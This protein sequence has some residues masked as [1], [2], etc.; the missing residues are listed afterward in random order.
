[1]KNILY[2]V[3]FISCMT[4]CNQ[5]QLMNEEQIRFV[6][7]PQGLHFISTS[8]N[9]ELKTISA[10]YGNEIAISLLEN[11]LHNPADALLKCVTY[12]LQ[13]SPAYFGSQVNGELLS[14]E[15]LTKHAN[16]KDK[17]N[18]DF[19]E[20]PGKQAPA[21]RIKSILNTRLVNFP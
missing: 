13:D 3:L 7:A 19:G 4:S 9:K 2:F 17:Y 6:F 12:R 20:V 1:M 18:I 15:T 21:E 11:N 10:I 14:V 16:G 8:M 5:H